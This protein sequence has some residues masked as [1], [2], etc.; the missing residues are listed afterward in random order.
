[1]ATANENSDILYANS[2][3]SG[4]ESMEVKS[5]FEDHFQFHRG[6]DLPP[7]LPPHTPNPI[8]LPRIGGTKPKII[9]ATGS[10]RSPGSQ[11]PRIGVKYQWESQD[12]SFETQTSKEGSQ[13]TEAHYKEKLLLHKT[14]RTIQVQESTKKQSNMV[15]N[16]YICITFILSN[17]M[18][19]GFSVLGTI[20]VMKTVNVNH[21]N[22]HIFDTQD[23]FQI[24]VKNVPDSLPKP[25]ESPSMKI[26]T[27]NSDEKTAEKETAS[28]PPTGHIGLTA[29]A[30]KDYKIHIKVEN[31]TIENGQNDFW[32]A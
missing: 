21:C 1:M 23:R 30:D 9:V 24:P 11:S 27:L 13:Y 2:T 19:I 7:P 3:P 10:P 29:A 18:A 20:L 28:D 12:T 15:I 25:M 32:F 22:P 14:L 16:K 4:P 5:K 8:T 6:S 17:I 31:K 26:L